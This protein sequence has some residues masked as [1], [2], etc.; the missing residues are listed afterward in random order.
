VRTIAFARHETLRHHRQLV[1]KN[2]FGAAIHPRAD[3]GPGRNTQTNGTK[4]NSATKDRLGR[5]VG[6]LRRS[7]VET[8]RPREPKTGPF[9]LTLLYRYAADVSIVS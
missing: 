6:V 4:A 9:Q 1:Q 8:K 3:N 7:L 5:D 2:D